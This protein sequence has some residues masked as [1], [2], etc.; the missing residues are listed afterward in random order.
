MSEGVAES[1]AAASPTPVAPSRQCVG[2]GFDVM[3]IA[4][5]GVCSE[6]Q[7]PVRET[8]LRSML[9]ESRRSS[10]RV[11]LGSRLL[12][13][14]L[15]SLMLLLLMLAV[16]DIAGIAWAS[17]AFDQ[18][19]ALDWALMLV[20]LSL[21]AA[22]GVL[23][24]RSSRWAMS[25]QVAFALATMM[26]ASLRF[27]TEWF[28]NSPGS[29]HKMLYLMIMIAANAVCLFLT[30][31]FLSWVVYASS[32][33]CDSFSLHSHAKRLRTATLIWGPAAAI[34]LITFGAAGLY[35]GS[36]PS[37]RALLDLAIQAAS[38]FGVAIVLPLSVSLSCYA[39]FVLTRLAKAAKAE[40]NFASTLPS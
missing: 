30:Y 4:M 5:D 29:E 7:K 19:P 33:A 14:A 13:F 10:R 21:N 20:L 28:W 2:C 27:M 18:H 40:A 25:T 34:L 39:L 6:C 23:L 22:G 16:E 26:P 15:M 11:V 1:G 24:M 12:F 9:R 37:L 32:L 35:G 8:V 38:V 3:G 17:A 31:T 36:D